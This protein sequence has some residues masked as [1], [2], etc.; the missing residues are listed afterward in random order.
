MAVDLC[1]PTSLVQSLCCCYDMLLDRSVGVDRVESTRGRNAELPNLSVGG[2][3]EGANKASIGF[4]TV[5]AQ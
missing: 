3:K 1:G 2:L 4:L 5:F